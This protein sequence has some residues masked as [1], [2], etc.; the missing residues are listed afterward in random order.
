MLCHPAHILCSD[1][2][3]REGRIHPRATG[4][5][6]RFAGRFVREGLMPLERAVQH[7]TSFPARRFG[8]GD[9][10]RIAAGCA[11]D[12]VVLDPETFSDRE[13]LGA[14]GVRD[15]I[16]NGVPAMLGG[17]PT[18]STP[19]RGLRRVEQAS[20]VRRIATTGTRG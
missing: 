2:I 1:G 10:G 14:T 13:G 4:A 20:F 15:V 9:R 16:V 17:E 3:Y 8:L 19:G 6:A 11:A 5:V 7:A 12:L 18:G